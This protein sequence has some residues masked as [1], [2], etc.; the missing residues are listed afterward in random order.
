MAKEGEA[1]KGWLNQDDLGL[2]CLYRLILM[3]LFL[4]AGLAYGMDYEVTTKAGDY[5]VEVKFDRNPPAVGDN[6]MMVWLKDAAGNYVK[7]AN[8]TIDY[9]KTTLLGLS[10]MMSNAYAQPH[11]KN[12]HA[13]LEI[14]TQGSWNVTINIYHKEKKVST[15]FSI[16]V[17]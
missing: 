14:P 12:Y 7:D 6:N 3:I 5:S 4:S 1:Q 17:K 8:I 13:I 9:T 10:K 15:K 2:S 11:G 16:D